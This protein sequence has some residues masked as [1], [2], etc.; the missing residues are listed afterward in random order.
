MQA[1]AAQ[2]QGSV[3]N[4]MWTAG[5]ER[6]DAEHRTQMVQQRSDA[7]GRKLD[8]LRTERADLLNQSDGTVTAR[9]RARAAQLLARIE[10]LQA[11]VNDTQT[12]AKTAGVDASRLDEIRTGARNLTG[13]EVSEMARGPAGPSNGRGPAAKSELPGRD[14]DAGHANGARDHTP[15]GN[16]DDRAGSGVGAGNSNRGRN[17]A[18]ERANASVTPDGTEGTNQT[19]S[20]RET[21][22]GAAAGVTLFSA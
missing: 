12:A 18:D 3:E 5:F 11:A 20:V 14:G 16:A 19:E 10:S 13:P 22:E 2:A 7:L 4:G 9:D 1:S 15:P 21:A 17:G 6:A 8:R